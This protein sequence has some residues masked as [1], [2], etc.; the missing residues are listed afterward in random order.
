[1]LIKA[2]SLKKKS[3]PRL[4]RDPLVIYPPFQAMLGKKDQKGTSKEIDIRH[5]AKYLLKEG[6]MLEKREL[7]VNLKSGIVYKNKRIHLS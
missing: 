7:L 1:M 5:Y 6:S 3:G 4:R 2:Y